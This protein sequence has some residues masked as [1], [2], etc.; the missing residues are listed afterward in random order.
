MYP[1]QELLKVPVSCFFES[2]Q[3]FE[4]SQLRKIVWSQREPEHCAL[5]EFLTYR[6][7]ER[8]NMITVVCYKFGAV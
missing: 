2:P 3:I 1:K 4:S 7:H 5:S 6:F 8:Y